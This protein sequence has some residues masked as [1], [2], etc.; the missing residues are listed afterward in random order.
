MKR[1]TLLLSLLVAF[2]SCQKNAPT[3][4][5]LEVVGAEFDQDFVLAYQQTARLPGLDRPAV[6]V[7]V[8]D[9]EDSRCPQ[10]MNCFLAGVA[11]AHVRVVGRESGDQ[12]VHVQLR[13]FGGTQNVTDSAGVRANGA[14]YVLYIRRLE[15]GPTTTWAKK[16][17]QR[18]TLRLSRH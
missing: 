8:E 10:G 7:T 18:V 2:A 5:P 9:I 1:T 13:D 16:E 17:E 14:R 15:P 6:R 11:G 3:P 4:T 12:R